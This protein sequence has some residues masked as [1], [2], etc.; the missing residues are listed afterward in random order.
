MPA[1]SGVHY[2]HPTDNRAGLWLQLSPG[3]LIG[4]PRSEWPSI[5]AGGSP[6]QRRA[7]FEADLNAQFEPLTWTQRIPLTEM[8]GD[9]VL[10][11][12]EPGC[13]VTATHYECQSV[14]LFIRV[15]SINPIEVLPIVENPR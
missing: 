8:A 13:R 12:P 4:F 7:R 1:V 11:S 14:K 15:L 6:E 3:P 2:N 9:P 5:G 10:T